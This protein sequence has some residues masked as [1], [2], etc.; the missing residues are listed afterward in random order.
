MKF[1][2]RSQEDVLEDL[3]RKLEQLPPQ[4]P[5]RPALVRMIVGLQ[6]ELALRDASFP[7]AHERENSIQAPRRAA[8]CMRS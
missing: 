4:H 2:T 1:R 7:I 8:V 3:V 6:G 5:S